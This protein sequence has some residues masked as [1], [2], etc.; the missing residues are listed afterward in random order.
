ML[1]NDITICTVKDYLST[2]L[3]QVYHMYPYH[4][5]ILIQVVSTTNV[6]S[7]TSLSAFHKMSTSL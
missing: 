2:P 4:V 6:S 5:L 1:S 7:E 3:E